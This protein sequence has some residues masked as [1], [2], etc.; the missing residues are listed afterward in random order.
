LWEEKKAQLEAELLNATDHVQME[1]I[2]L[3]L[4]ALSDQIDNGTMRWLELSEMM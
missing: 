2:A 1:K 3:E 4:G